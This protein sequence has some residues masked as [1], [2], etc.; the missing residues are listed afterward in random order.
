MTHCLYMTSKTIRQSAQCVQMLFGDQPTIT[1]REQKC[2]LFWDMSSLIV[3]KY[4]ISL[5]SRDFNLTVETIPVLIAW[6]YFCLEAPGMKVRLHTAQ[7][8]LYRIILISSVKKWLVNST[9]QKKFFKTWHIEVVASVSLCP[10]SFSSK[11]LIKLVV[12]RN[13]N[14]SE[15]FCQSNNIAV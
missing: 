8:F 11:R 5:L 2:T 13:S 7:C 15:V 10:R 14:T 4:F 1:V 12:Q 9:S 3:L 6:N